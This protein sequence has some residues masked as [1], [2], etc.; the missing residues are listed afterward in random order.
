MRKTGFVPII[1]KMLIT[2]DGVSDP[3][4]IEDRSTDNKCL[5]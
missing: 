3:V 2:D 4:N 1:V 5:Q